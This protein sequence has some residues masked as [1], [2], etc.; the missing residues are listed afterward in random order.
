MRLPFV[1]LKEE[2]Q[3]NIVDKLYG[4]VRLSENFDCKAE[5]EQTMGKRY[6]LEVLGN[7]SE[8]MDGNYD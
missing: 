2:D 3:S 8:L 1:E 7:T 5:V 6:L 4:T